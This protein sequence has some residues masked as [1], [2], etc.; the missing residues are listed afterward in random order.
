MNVS[1]KPCDRLSGTGMHRLRSGNGCVT[2]SLSGIRREP[3]SIGPKPT[4]QAFRDSSQ[5]KDSGL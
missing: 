2:N 3:E 1:Q 5:L 4:M